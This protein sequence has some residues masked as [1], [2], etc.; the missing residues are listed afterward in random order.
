MNF[1]KCHWTNFAHHL[2]NIT[3][4]RYKLISIKRKSLYN[5]PTY[6]PD[7]LDRSNIRCACFFVLSTAVLLVG[8]KLDCSSLSFPWLRSSFMSVIGVFLLVVFL[9][10]F[11]SVASFS[12]S[13]PL[14]T[15]CSYCCVAAPSSSSSSWPL[16][17]TN[18]F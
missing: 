15:L 1:K 13:L 18:L 9:M 10:L 14:S 5:F 6:P 11:N 2:K 4:G 3:L 17:Y 7:Y 16:V 8:V 12:S